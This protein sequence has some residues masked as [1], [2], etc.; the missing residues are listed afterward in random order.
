MKLCKSHLLE[1][2]PVEV[3][4]TTDEQSQKGVKEEAPPLSCLLNILKILS[5]ITYRIR[6][7]SNLIFIVSF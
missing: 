4:M 1:Q 2:K 6:K 7:Y 3:D 5:N